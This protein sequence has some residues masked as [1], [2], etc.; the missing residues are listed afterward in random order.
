MMRRPPRSTLF[1]YT[2]LFR[3]GTRGEEAPGLV[4]RVAAGRP[5]LAAERDR[6]TVSGLRRSGGAVGDRF[7]QLRPAPGSVGEC[8]PRRGPGRRGTGRQ[9]HHLDR[10][11]VPASE[12][13]LLFRHTELYLADPPPEPEE[14]VRHQLCGR[15]VQDRQS[16]V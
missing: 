16:V 7:L 12:L 6:R 9:G 13:W 15:D 8:L 2:T 5:A 11:H 14:G 3:S 1:P 4:P 10:N